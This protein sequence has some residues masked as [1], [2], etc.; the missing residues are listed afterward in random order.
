MKPIEML[1]MAVRDVAE[2]EIMPY[3]LKTAYLHKADCSVLS[4]ADLAA[5]Q[6]LV[7]RLREIIDVPVLGEEMAADVQLRLWR[8]SADGLWVIDPIDGTNNFVN[9]IPHFAVS[10]AFV[11]QGRTQMGLVFNPVSGECFSAVRGF[12][13]FLNGEKLPLR[14]VPKKLREAIA[15]VD[16]KR[17]RSAKL[18][19]SIHHFA[20]FGTSRCLGSSTLDWCYLAAGR[21]DIYIH[22]GQN[23]WDYAAGALIFEESGGLLTTLE[24]DDFWSGLHTFKRSVI[25][26]GQPELFESWV[27]WIRKN[28]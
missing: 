27:G 2:R 15:G 7:F 3:F 26:A 18:A 4:Q 12:G 23:F 25:A 28:Q 17:L 6:A 1:E 22:G 8:D 21:Y 11:Q 14:R 9:G 20:P 10:A 24:G 5:Q 16:M 19:S 13:A